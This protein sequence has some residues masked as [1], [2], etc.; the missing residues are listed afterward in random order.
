[1]GQQ[2][3]RQPDG[4]PSAWEVDG[5]VDGVYTDGVTLHRRLARAVEMARTLAGPTTGP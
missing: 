5:E 3:I 2:I 1:M 4:R